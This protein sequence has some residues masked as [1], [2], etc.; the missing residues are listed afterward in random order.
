[1]PKKA[2]LPAFTC[3]L[4]PRCSIDNICAKQSSFILPSC[5][6]SFNLD[7]DTPRV[8]G[9]SFQQRQVFP[10][11]SVKRLTNNPLAPSWPGRDDSTNMQ[12]LAPI[13]QQNNLYFTF[14]GMMMNARST[15]KLSFLCSLVACSAA[16]A[17]STSY[18]QKFFGGMKATRKLDHRHANTL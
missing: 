5:V 13:H 11:Y 1:M 9:P 14:L 4:S 10:H 8:G 17:S 15:V 7:V 16:L 2:T 18:R 3:T 12:E 6:G